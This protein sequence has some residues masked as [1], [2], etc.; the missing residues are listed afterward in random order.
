ME[1]YLSDIHVYQ[2]YELFKRLYTCI[3]SSK[4]KDKFQENLPLVDSGVV[5]F[6]TKSRTAVISSPKPAIASMTSSGME[7]DVP[8]ALSVRKKQKRKMLKFYIKVSSGT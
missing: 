7:V 1:F 2:L 8:F 6:F 4:H 3:S 5:D